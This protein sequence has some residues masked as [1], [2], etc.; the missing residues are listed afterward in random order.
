VRL[1]DD[2]GKERHVYVPGESLTVVLTVRAAAPIADFVFGLGLF[3][4][5]GVSVFGSNTQLE[6]YE[7]KR[8]QGEA[9]V[10]LVLE[11]LRL[12]EGTYLVDVAAHRRD[13][14]PYDYHRGL[15]SF[16]VRSRVKD[17]GVYRPHH[18]WRFSGGAEITAP[19]A[20]PELDLHEEEPPGGE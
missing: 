2:R 15:T 8:L 13:G 4:A 6:D 1:L 16:R 18:R 20:R 11:D 12:T 3:T 10:S 17:V 14:T 19:P 5:D 7:P 9:E